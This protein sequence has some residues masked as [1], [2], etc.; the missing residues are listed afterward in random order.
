MA[1]ARMEDEVG[2]AMEGWAHLVFTSQNEEEDEGWTWVDESGK[3][4]KTEGS[5]ESESPR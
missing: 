4:P 2:R 1:P 5:K 3:A